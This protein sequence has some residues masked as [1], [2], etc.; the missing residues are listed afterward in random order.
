LNQDLV[1]H[2][3]KVLLAQLQCPNVQQRNVKDQATDIWVFI[4]HGRH[5]TLFYH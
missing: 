2:E 5:M 4:V 3:A 1:G